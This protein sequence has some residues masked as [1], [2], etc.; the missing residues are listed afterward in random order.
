MPQE[1]TIEEIQQK[2]SKGT[3]KVMTAHE[4][5]QQTYKG[6]VIKFEDVDVLTTATKGLMSGTSAILAFRIGEPGE[7]VKAKSLTMNDIPCYVGP[8][9]NENLGLVDLIFY[10]TDKS[11]SNPKYGA[12]HLLRDLVERK[13]IQIKAITSEN[14]TIEK[15]LTLE[16]IYFAKM[17]GIRHAFRNYNAFINPSS[18]PIQ[19]I[20]TVLG[21]QPNSSEIT[22]CGCGVVNPLENDPNMEVIGIGS[23]IYV[24]GSMGHIIGSG[25]RSS[26]ERPNLM[27][28]AELEDMKPEYMGGFVTSNGPEVIVSMGLAIPILSQKQWDALKKN[29]KNVPLNIVDIVGRKVLHT[30]DYFQV[31]RKNLA[32]SFNASF[33]PTCELKE[34]CPVIEFCPTSCFTVGVGMDLSKCFNCGTCKKVCPKGAFACNL[35]EIEIEGRKIPVVL[36]ESDRNGAVKMMDE[37]RKKILKG[38]FPVVLPTAKPKIAVEKKK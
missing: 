1:R 11:S 28:I 18:T 30:T 37:L 22:V 17:M 14:K 35:G 31:W 7:F 24:N 5:C 26:P 6:E 9:P 23:P 27:T 32:M 33:C 16:D 10:A 21:M 12:G 36:R 34:K 3:A 38:E 4:L 8:C 19:S 13:P 20:F 2:I 25:T 29:D 15:I